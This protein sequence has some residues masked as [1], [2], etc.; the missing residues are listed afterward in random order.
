MN[1]SQHIW[2]LEDDPGA[3]FVYQESLGLK[4][5]LKFLSCA[6]DLAVALSN[7]IPTP[8]LLIADVRLPGESFLSFLNRDGKRIN[9][10]F[11]VISSVDDV[12][13]LRFCFEKGAVDYITKPFGKGELRVKVERYLRASPEHPGTTICA[14]DL[15]SLRVQRN[16]Q[17]SVPLTTKELQILQSL[18]AEPSRQK[19]KDSLMESVWGDVQVGGKTLDVHLFHLRQKIAPLGLKILFRGPSSYCLMVEEIPTPSTQSDE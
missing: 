1:S 2:V 18:L 9:C 8:E 3:Q 14:I 17:S 15:R 6:E 7:G 11:I 12:D 19:A 4:Y 13:A 5:Q 10:P 16:G